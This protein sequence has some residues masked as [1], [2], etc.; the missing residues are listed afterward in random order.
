MRLSSSLIGLLA[1]SL[2]TA[3]CTT[4]PADPTSRF[5][6]FDQQSDAAL[7]AFPSVYLAP[8]A[9]SEEIQ[10]R[11]DYR[12][13]AVNDRKRPL[14][15]RDVDQNVT[16]LTDALTS[17]LEAS[18]TFAPA[19]GQGVLTIAVT[20]ETLSASRPTQAELAAT[21]GLSINSIATGG[22]GVS[23]QFKEGETV[24]ATAKDAHSET[25]DRTTGVGS[26]WTEAKQFYRRAAQKIA[27]LLD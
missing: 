12:P 9:V 10:S 21:P 23:I 2:V 25:I 13:R 17:A 7:G 6:Q 20:L 11:I 14:G 4:T 27:G 26:P 5:D 19:P 1:L 24:L 8:I 16:S 22:A 3:A 15:Q 18:T